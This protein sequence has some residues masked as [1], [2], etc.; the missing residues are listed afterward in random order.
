MK[1]ILR[2]ISPLLIFSISACKEEKAERQ[3][4]VKVK[5]TTVSANHFSP[6]IYTGTIEE[7]A[8]TVLSFQVPGTIEEL[9]VRVGQYVTT[10][11][12]IA[13]VNP[14]TMQNTYD[15]S[16][17]VLDQARDAYDRMKG[18]HERGSIPEIQW[19]EVVSTLERAEASERLARKNLTDCK[20]R[21]PFSAV[22]ISRYM[23]IGQSAVPGAPVMKL[24]N[25]I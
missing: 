13:A 19:V 5:V 25:Q 21:A 15:V 8:G 17:A 6:D 20:L 22:V 2:I 7:D 9:P 12:E 3:P 18:L 16:K 1:T 24:G 10:G 4:P 23:E 11:Q 14:S